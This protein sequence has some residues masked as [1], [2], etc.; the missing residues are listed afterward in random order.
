VRKKGFCEQGGYA[1]SSISALLKQHPL[2]AFFGLTYGISW[3]LW[4]PLVI[5][6]QERSPEATLLIISGGFGPLLAA[7]VV[8]WIVE[9]GTGL[10][11]WRNR[12]FKWRVDIRLYA[13]AL[14]LPIVGA[15]SAF[16]L[17]LLLGGTTPEGWTAPP[18]FAYII[19]FLF[20]L[21]LG[22]GQE[23][24]GWR[25]FALPHLQAKTNPLIASLILGVLWAFWHFP[26]FFAPAS[27]QSGNSLPFLWYMLHTVAITIVFT[28]LFNST[29]GS[30]LLPM[31]LHA[32]LNAIA[33]WVPLRATEGAISL[34]VSLVVVEWLIAIVL[35]VVYGP[36]RLSRQ[37][38]S[39]TQSSS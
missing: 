36:A 37:Q 8:T 12:I 18:W 26:L 23:E 21:F 2:A 27:S 10:S 25:G 34:F 33:S 38:S 22:G 29:G 13:F 17:Y 6:G 31:L 7:L 32:R 5:S 30:V 14:L 28:W 4:S 3:I 39:R 35:S 24:P 15:F 11:E 1:V 20:V 16:G 9:G 19:A